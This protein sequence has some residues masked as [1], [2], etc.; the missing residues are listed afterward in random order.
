MSPVI[1]ALEAGMTNCETLVRGCE[2]LRTNTMNL[3]SDPL[4]LSM[5]EEKKQLQVS[6]MSELICLVWF[7]LLYFF[8]F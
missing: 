4:Y 8:R 1:L 6:L 7:R 5:L 3:E 2:I